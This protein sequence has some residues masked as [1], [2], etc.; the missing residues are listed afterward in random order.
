MVGFYDPE[1]KSWAGHTGPTL[2]SAYG[3]VEDFIEWA[4][5]QDTDGVTRDYAIFSVVLFNQ[6]YEEAQ[7]IQGQN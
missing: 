7:F 4:P 3:Y 2:A 5:L 1:T 6:Y